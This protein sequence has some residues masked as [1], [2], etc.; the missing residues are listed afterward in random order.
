MGAGVSIW[1]RIRIASA[2]R[3]WTG[4]ADRAERLDPQALERLRIAARMVRGQADRLI[5][6]ASLR[7]PG[8]SPAAGADRPVRIPGA[9]LHEAE[10]YGA[11]WGADWIWRPDLW[12]GEQ[13]FP[14]AGGS[15]GIAGAKSGMQICEAVSLFHDCPLGEIT[16][17]QRPNPR[18]DRDDPAR[19]AACG[20]E[21]EVFGFRGSFMSLAFDMPPAAVAG[22]RRR[23][24]IRLDAVIGAERP[25]SVLARLNVRH[26]PNLAQITGQVTRGLIGAGT[27]EFPLSG[28][29]PPLVAEFDLAYGEIDEARIEKIWIDLFLHGPQM[30]CITLRDL[31]LCRHPRA[32]L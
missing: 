32:A 29:H 1:D 26:G 6:A 16:C 8:S 14:A 23:H 31:T 24:V 21:I 4:L 13:A 11:E 30:N 28:D 7:P 10:V 19:D 22:V 12:R 25:L 27:A 15:L 20:L 3:F 17:R 9:H 18:R 5:R 2:Q